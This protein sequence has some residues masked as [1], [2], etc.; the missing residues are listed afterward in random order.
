MPV[1]SSIGFYVGMMISKGNRARD[2]G[3][4]HV[5]HEH[6]QYGSDARLRRQCAPG[7]HDMM[8]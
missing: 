1:L 6:V 4:T 5:I 3:T 8:M 7:L 2:D